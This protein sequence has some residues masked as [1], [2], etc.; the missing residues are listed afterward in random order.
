MALQVEIIPVTPF[1]QNCCLLWDADTKEAVLTDVGGNADVLWAR[2]EELGLNLKEIWLTHGHV[3]HAGGVADL[4]AL[5]EV[6]VIGPHEGDAFW[7]DQLPEAT[8][9]YGF[10]VSPALTPNKWLIEGDTVQVGAHAFSV[11]H[12][13]GHTPGHVVFYS[14][15]YG[16]II[17]GDI[18]F[19]GSIGR[20]DFPRGNHQ[21]LISNIQNKLYVLPDATDVIPGH[22]PM[23]NIG[24]EKRSNPFVQAAFG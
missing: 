17:G 3:D 1:Q 21:D 19:K 10:P 22:G 20:T 4:R 2:I 13:P 11:L 16:L 18:L 6:P 12:I 7:L 8:S 9:K 5:K 23:T 24:D 15:E 14:A